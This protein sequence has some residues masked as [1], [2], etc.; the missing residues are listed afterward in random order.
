MCSS[1][2][3]P[4]SC[5]VPAWHPTLLPVHTKVFSS[6]CFNF[7]KEAFGMATKARRRTARCIE[8]EQERWLFPLFLALSS[9]SG[10]QISKHTHHLSLGTFLQEVLGSFARLGWTCDRAHRPDDSCQRWNSPLVHVRRSSP[11]RF[12]KRSVRDR[13]GF[14]SACEGGWQPRGER[15]EV[16]SP[17]RCCIANWRRELWNPKKCAGPCMM[18]LVA[19]G[20]VNKLNPYGTAVERICSKGFYYVLLHAI[21]WW[22]S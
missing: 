2:L 13:R 11:G 4:S 18:L 17:S 3:L 10:M 16:H 20:R 22:M 21:E 8:I 1:F 9:L 7:I 14:G 15:F 12:A 5:L 19:H 6:S